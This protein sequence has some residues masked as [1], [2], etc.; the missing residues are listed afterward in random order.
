[1]VN[2]SWLTHTVIFL[3]TCYFVEMGI[4]WIGPKH[5]IDIT[6]VHGPAWPTVKNNGRTNN[7][8]FKIFLTKPGKDARAELFK[9]VSV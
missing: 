6:D 5:G 2:S 1:M 9:T 4:G 7:Y 3:Y 8:G